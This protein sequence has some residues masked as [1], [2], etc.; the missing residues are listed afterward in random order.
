MTQGGVDYF[1]Y[2]ITPDFELLYMIV[3]QR[4]NNCTEKVS[5]MSSS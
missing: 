1:I 4:I 3:D 2:S 5:L